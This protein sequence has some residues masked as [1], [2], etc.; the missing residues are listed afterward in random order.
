MSEALALDVGEAPDALHTLTIAFDRRRLVG[1]Q[2]Y[3][4]LK[5]SIV[6]LRLPPGA[7][8]SENRICS[9][10]GVS[11]TPVR[12]AIIRLVE[13]GL[14]E[15]FPQKGSFV[16][17]IKLSTVRNNHFIR[18]AIEIAVLRR[19][20]PAWTR[21]VAAR[22]RQILARQSAAL[23]EEDI[24]RF[25]ELDEA[26]HR[27]FCTAA[28]LDGVWCTIQIAKARV[29]RVH[30]LAAAQGRLPHVIAEHGDILDALDAGD[31]ARAVERLD[32]HL[33]RAPAIMETLIGAYEKYF[34]D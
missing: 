9:Q 12:T 34:V 2:I 18:K 10:I 3:E 32:Y 5:A 22:S 24:D 29:D 26:F 23:A 27:A 17:P 28:A 20:S 16:A 31:A 21:K 19:A 30:R 4:A 13:D 7:S 15:V 11:R 14:I 6:S 8:I 1:D 33:E 25:Y